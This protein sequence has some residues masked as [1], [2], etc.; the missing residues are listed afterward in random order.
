VPRRYPP[1]ADY[2]LIG[3]CHSAAL[4]S[5]GGSIDWCCLPRFDS[6]SCFGRLLDWEGGGYFAVAP[7]GRCASRRAYLERTLMLVTTFTSGANEARL[8]DFFAMREGGRSRPRRELV[9]IIEGV[10]GRMR[11]AVRV[12]PRF[13]FGEVRPWIYRAGSQGFAAAGANMG[14]LLF[15]DVELEQGAPHEL[16]AEVNVRRGERLHLGLQFVAPEELKAAQA[17]GEARERLAG[18]YEETLTWWRDWAAKL[19]YPEAAGPRIMRSAIVLKALTYAPT[20]AIIAAPTTSLPEQAGGRRNW[21]YRFSWI[22]DS[23]FTVHALSALGL[24]AEAHGF[25]RFVQRSTA[26]NV[27]DLQVL[28]AVDGRRR[29]V[30]IELAHLDGWRGSRPVRIGNGAARQYQ[31]DLFGLVLEL[32]WR[33]SERGRSGVEEYWGF[34]R[35]VVEAAIAKWHLPDRGIWEVRSRPRHFVHSKVM[36]WAAVNRGIALAE[37]FSLPAPLDRW[38]AART[39]IRAAVES[40]GLDRKRGHFV[41]SFGSTQVDAALLLIPSVEFVPYQDERMVRTADAIDRTLRRS[42]L[43]LRYRTR[44]GLPRGEGV[45]LACT[46]WLAE[47][48]AHQGRHARARALFER[49][50]ACANDLD[51]FAEEYDARAGEML[52]N[53]PQ[54]LTHLAYISAAL[55]LN[56][57][58]TRLAGGD[59]ARATLGRE[60]ASGWMKRQRL[61]RRGARPGRSGR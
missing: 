54:G 40:R 15:G 7:R 47:C 20:G 17:R 50:T 37:R 38:R 13:D 29:M 2:A 8:I 5:R 30:E 31:A 52:G 44:D 57:S 33:W 27:E 48:F 16:A 3:D 34:L 24:E 26:G 32:S 56:A 21:D 43:I 23:V 46:F 41:E 18:H 6:E 1:I 45:F 49:A 35:D 59:R 12:V 39:K 53:F 28:Y 9:R 42:G 61:E 58:G 36:C 14:L 60:T 4:V 19:V 11:F 55:A 25:R 22:R 51:L 10:R